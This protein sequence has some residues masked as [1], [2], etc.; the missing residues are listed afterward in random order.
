M[1]CF[2]TVGVHHE[3][4]RLVEH[5]GRG[6]VDDADSFRAALDD[7]LDEGEATRGELN[8]LVDAVRL[9]TFARLESQVEHGAEIN[10]AISLLSADLSR[11]RGTTESTSAA[12]ALGVLAFAVGRLGEADL[13]HLRAAMVPPERPADSD[14]R[15]PKADAAPATVRRPSTVPLDEEAAPDRPRRAAPILLAVGAVVLLLV[16]AIAVAQGWGRGDDDPDAADDRSGST[17]GAE[18]FVP[19]TVEAAPATNKGVRSERT[20]RLTA[21]RV[22]STVVLT[23][24]TKAPLIVLWTE[25][26]PKEL[27]DHVSLVTFKPADRQVLEADPIVYWRLTLP[28]KDSRQVRWST[29]V[30]DGA[31]PSADYL[32]RI[33]GWHEEAVTAGLP[34]IR[35]KV[36]ELARPGEVVPIPDVPDAEVPVV[37]SPGESGESGESGGAVETSAPVGPRETRAANRAPRI[38]LS[39]TTTNEQVNGG[40]VVGG[41]DPDGDSWSV[42]AVSGAPAGIGRTGAHAL[43]GTVSHRAS[44]ATSNRSTIRSTSYRVTVTI[45]DSHGLRDSGTFTWTVRDTHRTMPNYLGKY[46][47]N[48]DIG[49]LFVPNFAGCLDT[50]RPV[51]TIA[52][53]SV[54]AGAIVA[55]G[56]SPRFTYVHHDGSYPAC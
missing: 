43:G 4:A 49:A 24:T 17:A 52:R 10:P 19:I 11:D 15:G 16:G 32:A 48:P 44:S 29:A 23:N 55:W 26:V 35:R 47:D 22:S 9:G 34:Q 1:E 33:T 39:A 8:L 42:V 13:A 5:A 21:D 7:F 25:V 37:Q 3:V 20:Y 56:S 36:P 14:A 30:P 45:E 31:T 38:S 6:V 46:G 54:A 28:A 53:Q 41:S 50:G 12:W 18:A 51:D 2:L 27:A 40:Y